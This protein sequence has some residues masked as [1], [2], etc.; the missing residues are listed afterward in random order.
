VLA[1]LKFKRVA[2]LAGP[3]SFGVRPGDEAAN[4]VENAASAAPFGSQC[5]VIDD[6]DISEG[7]FHARSDGYIYVIVP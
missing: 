5:V 6:G 1:F 3:L 7:S 2:P 4:Y